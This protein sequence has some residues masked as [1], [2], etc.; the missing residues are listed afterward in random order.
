MTKKHLA[1]VCLTASMALAGCDK[2][3]TVDEFISSMIDIKCALQV[4]CLGADATTCRESW[5][6]SELSIYKAQTDKGS[7]TFIARQAQKCLDVLAKRTCEDNWSGGGACNYDAIF[8]GKLQGGAACIYSNE[9]AGEGFCY[10]D[11]EDA[12]ACSGV[13]VGPV[14]VGGTCVRYSHPRCVSSAWCNS[15][16]CEAYPKKGERCAPVAGCGAG[17]Y[18]DAEGVCQALVKEGERC[19]PDVRCDAGLFC[20][21]GNVCASRLGADEPCSSHEACRDGLACHP[22]EWVCSANIG[23]AGDKCLGTDQCRGIARCVIAPGAS[24]GTC[25]VRP[26]VGE[27]CTPGAGD[28]AGVWWCSLETKKCTEPVGLGEACGNSFGKENVQCREGYCRDGSC[29]A[30]RKEG[31]SCSHGVPCGGKLKCIE[32][33]CQVPPEKPVPENSCEGVLAP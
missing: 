17:L 8:V 30:Y 25:E 10:W 13:C 32:G 5:Q 12:D 19:G 11:K 20:N 2:P 3:L 33:T 16:V 1:A 22:F 7:V 21:A 29:V 27:D 15:G 6:D 26:K 31:E 18:C 4:E 28:C 14:P 9:C 23:R 24:E